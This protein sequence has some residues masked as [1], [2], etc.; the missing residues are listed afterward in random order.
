MN[1]RVNASLAISNGYLPANR[2]GATLLAL[3][4]AM[5]HLVGAQFTT[6]FDNDTVEV[7]E[8]T[9]L[10]LIFEDIQMQRPPQLPAM[11]NATVN[12]AGPAR[13]I[14]IVNGQS[15]STI[16]YRYVVTPQGPGEV[17]L[18]G[19]SVTMDGKTY[20]SRPLTLK[21][22]KGSS[23]AGAGGNEEFVSLK[24]VLPRQE[25]FYGETFPVEVRLYTALQIRELN[26][27]VPKLALEGFVIGKSAGAQQSQ[28]T[29]NNRQYAVITWR[30]SAT[31]AKLGALNVG[32]AETEAVIQVPNRSNRRRDPFGMLD[33][34]FG[35]GE[36]R[37]VQLSS[38]TNVLQVVALPTA[39]KPTSFSGAV[40]KFQMEVEASPTNLAV[41]EPITV[42]VR[43]S[44]EGNLDSL[45]PPQLAETRGWKSYPPT[46]H[47]QSSDALGIQGTKT[48]EFVIEPESAS[49]AS[50]PEIRFS[51]FDPETRR[52]Q[53]IQHPPIPLTVRPSKVAQAAP[54]RQAVSGE[55]MTPAGGSQEELRHIRS[56]LGPIVALN[57]S[58]RAPW[59]LAFGLLPLPLYWVFSAVKSYRERLANDPVRQRRLQSQRAI[60]DCLAMLKSHAQANQAPEFFAAL[61]TLL[62][63]RIGLT[64]GMPAAGIT[65]AVLE[66]RLRPHGLAEDHL[67]NLAELFETI[68]QARYSPI[69]TV[70]E[71]ER[72]RTRA[73]SACAALAAL[74]GKA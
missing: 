32:P 59:A 55:P 51:Y 42:R 2:G 64:L 3:V 36:Y 23:G 5:L 7:G 53:S 44:G 72:V 29:I 43:I 38:V 39:G 18:P 57:A 6:S 56:S 16:T 34:F 50:I 45:G 24:V 58:D 12:Y 19:L 54:S 73:E 21:V 37:R 10:N 1:F 67:S 4:W 26:P 69:S 35:G 25:V 20:S 60:A 49:L 11:T 52:Y 61:G 22:T 65:E 28:T 63:E 68:N 13:T 17:R 15:T 41:G 48:Y 66:E 74:E 14:S 62:Q 31:A 27:P 71:L 40:G 9:M 47:L 33:D 8:S 30:M 70:T 46:E